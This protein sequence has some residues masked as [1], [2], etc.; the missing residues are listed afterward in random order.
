MADYTAVTWSDLSNVPNTGARQDI[1]DALNG[2]IAELN[3]ANGSL[4]TG[5]AAGF[6]GGTG[7]V[8]KSSVNKVGGIYHTRIML[9]LT[10]LAGSATDLDIIGTGTAAAHIGQLTAAQNGATI[11]A[12]QMTCLE[13]PAGGPDDIDLYSATEGTG[14]YDT[15]IGTL[16]ETALI[17][18]GGAWANGTVKGA[19]AVPAAGQYLYLVNGEAA[20]G[21]TYTAGKFVIDIFGYD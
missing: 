19:T 6:T 5:A 20:A 7:T 15:G 8:Y 3:A 2:L 1:K 4:T 17:T 13:L 18:A 16:T 12:V 11:L 9:D 10:G 21:G 14:A